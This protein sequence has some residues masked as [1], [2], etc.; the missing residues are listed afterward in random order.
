[1]SLRPL[2]AALLLA[3]LPTAFVH[4]APP[5][6]ARDRVVILITVDGFPAWL[7][8]DPALPVP[9]L[10]KL[11]DEGAV[12]D[13][14]EVVNPSITWICH[15]TLVTGVGPIQHGVL[16]NGL[17]VRPGKDQPPMIDQWRD[18]A[19]LVRV[20]TVYDAAHKAGLKTAQ[21]DWVAILNSGTIDHEFLELPKPDGEIER[22]LIAAGKVTPADLHNFIKGKSPAWRDM[23]YNDAAID[24][25]TK[26]HP[27]LL[28]L[29]YLNTDA[30]NHADGPGSMASYAAYAL[31]DY[32]IRDLLASLDA[33]GYK[34]KATVII[35]TDHGFKKV[36]TGIW[37]N[38]A[39]RKAGLI[40]AD[41]PKVKKCD[42]YTVVEGG[43]AFVYV[44]D[45]AKRE[46]LLPKL[47]ELCTGLE[48]VD[49][50]I[51][52]KDA[53]TID[54]PTPTE[55]QGTGDLI[56]TAKAGYAFQAK[57]DG[58]ATNGDPKGYYGT[59][60]YL[61][62]D[63]ELDGAFI[64]WGYGIKPGTKLGKIRNRDVA[65]TVAELLGVPLPHVEGNALTEMLNLEPKP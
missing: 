25:L 7:W 18:K 63:P 1:M 26:H 42:A 61:A 60:G 10:R 30:L 14:M 59:H 47:R 34:D 35:T 4:A 17:L 51:D 11:A 5:V 2:F 12:A 36:K 38:V 53:H 20:P 32:Q 57:V 22:D 39:L 50:V 54:I 24:I 15:T 31:V 29:H 23:I 21:V 43:L 58:D 46:A 8:H 16:F 56:L 3:A 52:G 41:G 65:P 28:L 19:E 6:P 13:S 44:P 49:K 45:P 27:N 55:N 40:D 9:T 64:A 62:S 37:P 33:A 48:G